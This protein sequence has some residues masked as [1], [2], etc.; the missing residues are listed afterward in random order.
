MTYWATLY[1][2]G[3]VVIAMGFEGQTLAQCEEITALMMSDIVSAYEENI[4]ELATSMFPTNEFTVD[5]ETEQLAIAE[6]YLS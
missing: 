2:A 4:P 5:C 6:E 3:Q 1:Y